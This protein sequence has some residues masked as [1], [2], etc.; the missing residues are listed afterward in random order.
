MVNAPDLSIWLD[1]SASLHVGQT[2]LVKLNFFGN[3]RQ[4]CEAQH[5]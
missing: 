5:F 1:N 4:N 2:I 3:G